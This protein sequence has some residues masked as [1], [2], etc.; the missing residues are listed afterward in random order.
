[1]IVAKF[2]GTSVGTAQNIQKVI[3]IIAGKQGNS[4]VVVSALGGITNMLIKAS[5]LALQ[6]DEAYIKVINEI[7]SRPAVK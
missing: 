4:I 1:M 6:G 5:E 2:G 7:E 3:Q